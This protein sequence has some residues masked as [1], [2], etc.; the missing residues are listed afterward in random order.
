MKNLQKMGG[1]AALYEAAAYIIGIIGFLVVVDMS[2]LA[3][4]VQRVAFIAENQ[5]ALSLLHMIVYVIWGAVMVVLALA[6]YDRLKDDTPALAQIAAAF[7]VIWGAL[8][9]ASGMIYNVGMETAV[10]LYATD[11]AQAGTVWTAIE[12]VYTGLGGGNEIVGG[13]WVL[14]LSIAALRSGALPR[15]LNYLGLV[16]ATAGLLS[17][18]PAL[19]EIG[20]MVFGLGQIVWFVWLGIAMLRSS[21]AAESSAAPVLATAQKTA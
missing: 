9:I 1:L 11:P 21:S 19:N 5:T 14:L 18:V 20:V 6:L 10:T 17:A 12:S 4:P 16:I 13:I 3:D 15:L 2:G 8:I 7:G